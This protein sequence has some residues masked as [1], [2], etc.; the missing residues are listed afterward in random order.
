MTAFPLLNLRAVPE[1]SEP[2]EAPDRVVPAPGTE[3]EPG[4]SAASAGSVAGVWLVGVMALLW[5]RRRG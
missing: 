1:A 4:C 5:S 3:S 2:E